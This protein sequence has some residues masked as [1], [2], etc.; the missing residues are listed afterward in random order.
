MIDAPGSSSK[1]VPNPCSRRR[2]RKG[3]LHRPPARPSRA[4]P[5]GQGHRQ[6]RPDR[7]NL[8]G[9]DRRPRPRRRTAA[10]RAGRPLRGVGPDRLPEVP[11][12]PLAPPRQLAKPLYDAAPLRLVLTDVLGDRVLGD[13]SKRLVIPAWDVGRAAVHVFKTPHH[14]RLTRDRRIPMVDVAM[15]TSAAP[16]YF[17]AAHIHGHRLIDGGVWAN[18]PTSS[19]SPRRSAS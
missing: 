13:S 18:H 16:T 14:K 7:R 6:L 19:Q 3:A 17:P 10:R 11:P 2:R 5:R 4:G 8:G 12:A 9:R 1:H 15:A